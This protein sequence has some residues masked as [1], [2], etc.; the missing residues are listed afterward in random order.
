M[1]ACKLSRPELERFI[2][3]IH[4]R[5]LTTYSS[6]QFRS[7]REKRKH[8]RRMLSKILRVDHAGEM[9]A[10]K[11]YAGQMAVLKDS[12]YGSLINVRIY[13]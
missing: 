5:Y 12:D 1:L 9:G 3:S 10:D 4:E 6:N 13:L 11:I 8:E 7:T 2:F